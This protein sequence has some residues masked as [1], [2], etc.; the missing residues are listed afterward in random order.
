MSELKVPANIVT[1]GPQLTTPVYVEPAIMI[2]NRHWDRL[3]KRIGN[4]SDALTPA[5]LAIG[6][7]FFGVA[8]SLVLTLATVPMSR[9]GSPLGISR[10]THAV[11]IATAVFATLFA[12]VGI[13]AYFHYHRT[14]EGRADQI[15]RDMETYESPQSPASS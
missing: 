2:S 15:V 6:S 4:H 5:W 13:A 12:V 8:A 10:T 11:L 1:G 7:A 3:K 14:E 9:V